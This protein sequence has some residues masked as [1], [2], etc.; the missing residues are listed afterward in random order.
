MTTEHDDAYE[1]SEGATGYETPNQFADGEFALRI[2][3]VKTA[4]KDTKYFIIFECTGRTGASEGKLASFMFTLDSARKG[5]QSYKINVDQYKGLMLAL[6]RDVRPSQMANETIQ[7]AFEGIVIRAKKATKNGYT[8]WGY[9]ELV[10]K[11]GD[12]GNEDG[13]ITDE[14]VDEAEGITPGVEDADPF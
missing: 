11:P 14:D 6:G 13:A 10:S 4:K 2:N 1:G 8:N 7:D 12:M 5:E 3:R 9:F